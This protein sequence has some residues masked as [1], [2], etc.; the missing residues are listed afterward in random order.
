M[1]FPIFEPLIKVCKSVASSWS[2]L[3]NLTMLVGRSSHDGTPPSHHLH[4]VSSI[5][6]ALFPR[7]GSLVIHPIRFNPEFLTYQFQLTNQ[8]LKTVQ[9]SGS[10]WKFRANEL[11]GIVNH[12]FQ[13]P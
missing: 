6:F 9:R 2:G 11:A 4:T 13:D 5:V 8:K 7:S 10:R 3:R 1:Y 12:L